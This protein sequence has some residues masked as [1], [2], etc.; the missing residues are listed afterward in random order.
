MIRRQTNDGFNYRD[1]CNDQKDLIKL[2]IQ[3]A[4]N[5]V[6]DPM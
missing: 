3:I 1:G 6:Y 5:C 4:R 2:E